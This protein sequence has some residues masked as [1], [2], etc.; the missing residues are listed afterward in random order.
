MSSFY[1]SEELKE[2]GFRQVGDNVLISRNASIYGAN[3]ISIGSNVRIDDFAILSGNIM[4][5]NYVHIAAGVM[6][7]AGTAGV[8]LEDFVGVSSRSAI[9]ATSDDYSGGFLTNPMVPL[10]FRNVIEGRVIL[11]KHSLI[12]S[13]STILPNVVVGEGASVGSM[14]LINMDIDD[15]TISVGIPAREIKKRS[16]KVLELEKKLLNREC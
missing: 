6:I 7:F 10:Q 4:V 15:F 3:N 11:K 16:K 12:G 13:G 1:D 14:S 8:I 9:Y 5:G 2:I